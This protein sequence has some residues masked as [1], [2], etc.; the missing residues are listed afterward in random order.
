MIV[1]SK[2]FILTHSISAYTKT[3]S[4]VVSA[5]ENNKKKGLDCI[6][7]AFRSDFIRLLEPDFKTYIKKCIYTSAMCVTTLSRETLQLIIYFSVIS[8]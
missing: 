5:K 6:H 8:L 1:M 2:S 4:Q 7:T 3:C